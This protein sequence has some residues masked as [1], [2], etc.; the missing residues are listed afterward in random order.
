MLASAIVLF[1]AVD[2]KVF[3]DKLVLNRNVA[4]WI[5][6]LQ[7]TLLSFVAKD[8]YLHTFLRMVSQLVILNL[9]ITTHYLMM[10]YQLIMPLLLS[11]FFKIGVFI[12]LIENSLFSRR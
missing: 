6:N 2:V 9:M 1:S 10:G 8:L 3:A 11:L 5:F 4:K 7:I 12:F